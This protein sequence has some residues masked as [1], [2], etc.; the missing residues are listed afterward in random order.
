MVAKRVTDA[1]GNEVFVAEPA[2]MALHPMSKTVNDTH[3]GE[4]AANLEY[5]RRNRETVNSARKL[6]TAIG[7][8]DVGWVFDGEIL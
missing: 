5:A 3:N 2:A 6:V 7:I 1:D 8:V 4:N